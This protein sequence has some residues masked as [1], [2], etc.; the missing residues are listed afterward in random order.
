MG[1][2][3]FCKA[4]SP[5]LNGEYKDFLVDHIYCDPAGSQE[6]QTDEQTPFEIM[7][8]AGIPGEAAY[9]NN[10]PIIRRESLDAPLGRM[11][12]GKPGIIFSPKC[13]VLRKAM[14]GGYCF[15]RM[16]LS[17]EARFQ[18]KPVKN[19]FSHVAEAC[20]YLMTGSGE[21]AKLVELL[22]TEEEEPDRM[23]TQRGEAQ[24]WML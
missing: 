10:D 20:E 18:E 1:I 6:A 8:A 11:I 12:D 4:L 17:G 24:G 13:R 7:H 2:Q 19:K 14:M 23:Y 9:H 21:G 3:N 22:R 15:K 5:M 16:Q